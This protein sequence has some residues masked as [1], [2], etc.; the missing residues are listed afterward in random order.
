MSDTN[1]QL[2]P[3][4]N[5][6]AADAAQAAAAASAPPT[7]PDD[8][9][10]PQLGDDLAATGKGFIAALFDVSF[11][12]FITR[13]L[14]S[15][16]YVVGLIMIA[17]AF[18]YYFAGGLISG[19]ATLPWNPGGGVALIVSTVVIVP[20]AAFLGI[21]VLRFVIEGVVALIAIAENTERAAENTRRR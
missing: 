17:I 5:R 11:R 2:P 9:G 16:F 8:T 6:S 19:I 21:V 14:A 4:P 15:V 7:D 3:R 13:R 12:T 18:V 1:E 10:V 20:L